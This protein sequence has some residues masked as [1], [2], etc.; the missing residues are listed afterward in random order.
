MG[1]G[2]GEND[3]GECS[4]ATLNTQLHNH[5]QLSP[6]LHG[7]VHAVVRNEATWKAKLPFSVPFIMGLVSHFSLVKN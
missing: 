2:R 4:I 7:M 6:Q 3:S 5:Y 1:R